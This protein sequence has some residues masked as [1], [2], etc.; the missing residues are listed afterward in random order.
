MFLAFLVGFSAGGDEDFFGGECFFGREAFFFSSWL[1]TED[2]SLVR[3]PVLEKR[4]PLLRYVKLAL[5]RVLLALSAIVD[6]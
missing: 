5:Y 3:Y 2:N 6:L 4:S 1:E